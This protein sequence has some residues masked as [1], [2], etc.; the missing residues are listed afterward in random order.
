[1][2]LGRGL[3]A[4]EVRDERRLVRRGVVRGLPHLLE[5]PLEAAGGH[6]EHLGGLLHLVGVHQ[7]GRDEPEVTR[8]QPPRPLGPVLAGHEHPHAPVHHVEHLVRAVV[9]VGRDELTARSLHGEH[10]ELAP[11]LVAPQQHGEQVGEQHGV[12]T[13]APLQEEG[14]RASG[15]RALPLGSV[16]GVGQVGKTHGGL[17]GDVAG[18]A[19]LRSTGPGTQPV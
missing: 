4:R 12:L 11:G 5:E 8:L 6:P 19:T 13:L 17:R 2:G 10:A 16:A 3:H 1:M 9:A 7:A 15:Q 14:V 18:T